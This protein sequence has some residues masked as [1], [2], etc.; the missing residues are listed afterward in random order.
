ML[1]HSDY[2]IFSVRFS[3][4][5]RHVAAGGNRGDISIR[6]LRSGHLVASL[7]GHAERVSSIVF[8]PNGEG[9]ISGSWDKTLK[10]WDITGLTSTWML[11]KMRDGEADGA[12]KKEGLT[13]VGHR[14]RSFLF[15]DLLPDFDVTLLLPCRIE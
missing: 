12:E 7:R 9:L 14:V 15:S 2:D 13:F 8:M 6:E 11:D 4:D 5:G 1:G 10:Y 3:P